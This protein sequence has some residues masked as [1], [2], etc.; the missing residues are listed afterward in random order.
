MKAAALAVLLLSNSACA[1]GLDDLKAALAPLQGQGA[2]RGVYEAREQKTDQEKAGAKPELVQLSAQVEDDATGLQLRWD[3]ALLRRAAEEAAKGGRRNEVLTRAISANSGM[4]VAASVNYAPKLLQ[5]LAN[6]QLTL[7]R[8]DTWQ[9]R[10]ARL[11]ELKLA[12]PLD[13]DDRI[14][15]KESSHLA[16]VWLDADGTPLGATLS[17]KI[18]LSVMVFLSAER[19]SRDELSFIVQANRLVLLR[20]EEQG[21]EKNSAGESVFRNLYT[22]TPKG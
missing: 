16:Q 13:S 17:Q 9:G 11:L 20:R 22:F 1:N 5:M 18:R 2:L 10:P 7:E 12:P 3:R 14:K 19:A 15:V 6:C 21:S 8:A 4:R